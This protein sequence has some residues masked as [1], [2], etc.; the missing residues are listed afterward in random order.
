LQLLQP[1]L[2]QLAAAG[3]D[4]ARSLPLLL[5]Y[6]FPDSSLSALNYRDAQTGGYALFT[7]MTATI[8][9]DLSNLLC[10]YAIDPV[11]GAIEELEPQ[12]LAGD[13]CGLPGSTPGS[14]GAQPSGGATGLPELPELPELP[15]LPA[16]IPGTVVD[17]TAGTDG[18]PG[19]PQ[20]P[21]GQG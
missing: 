11:T 9:L 16:D 18:L 17:G 19:L 5:T 10:R 15:G 6:P 12:D 1:I 8:D 13:A 21:G 7:N 14:T 3:P 20:I 4:L 2:T